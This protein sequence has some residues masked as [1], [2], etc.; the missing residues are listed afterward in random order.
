MSDVALHGERNKAKEGLFKFAARSAMRNVGFITLLGA[1]AAVS[2]LHRSDGRGDRLT[3]F[4][5][6]HRIK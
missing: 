4:S 1:A 5:R 2:P 3:P 6:F